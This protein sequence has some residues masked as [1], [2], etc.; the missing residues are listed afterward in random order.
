MIPFISEIYGAVSRHT[1]RAIRNQNEYS[2]TSIELMPYIKPTIL[3]KIKY[4]KIILKIL[5]KL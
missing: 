4:R 1:A 3:L 2:G 5:S